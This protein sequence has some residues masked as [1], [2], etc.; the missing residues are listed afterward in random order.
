M[1]ACAGDVDNDGLI[2]LYVTNVGP[3]R[4]IA[5]PAAAG[6]PRSRTPAGADRRSWST[7][8]AFVDI[9]RDGYL[10]LFVTN[11]VD[12]PRGRNRF[13]G[14]A[15][16]PPIRDYCHPLIY[17]PLT[18][19]LYRNTG[20]GTFED[21]SVS[22]G[23]ARHRGNG[24]G[25]AVSDVDDDGWPDVFVANDSMPNFLFRNERNGTFTEIGGP[26]RRRRVGGRQGARPAWVRRSA[27]SPAPGA[28]AWSSR[29]T[30]PRCTACS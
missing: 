1:G 3:N 28:S 10:D 15:G 9:D 27:T 26:R 16:P 30:R 29:I 14:V 17:P 7:S 23:I 22:S 25:V 20:R 6:S 18:S 5:M 21:I 12:A 13:C 11:Y 8:C 24:L 4:S 2:D 19:A